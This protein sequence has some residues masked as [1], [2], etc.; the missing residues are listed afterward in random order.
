VLS[1]LQ[2]G[3][4]GDACRAGGYCNTTGAADPQCTDACSNCNICDAT[5]SPVL[6]HMKTLATSSIT[7]LDQAVEAYK[8]CTTGMTAVI[9]GASAEAPT[10]R[11]AADAGA[12]V[13]DDAK[14][15]KQPVPGQCMAKEEAR[16]S[17]A[18]KYN[19]CYQISGCRFNSKCRAI[20]AA[21]CDDSS[22]GYRSNLCRVSRGNA[23]RGLSNGMHFPCGNWPTSICSAAANTN[24]V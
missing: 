13:T 23:C 10:R 12:G 21:A 17:S 9:V 8:V 11:L 4:C 2:F 15:T 22:A 3:T 6:S 7:Q 1:A 24:L 5:L 19:S 14:V 16:C 20:D 18:P